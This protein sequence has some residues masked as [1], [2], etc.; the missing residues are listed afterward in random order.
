V[1]FFVLQLA[2]H[3]I[4]LVYEPYVLLVVIFPRVGNE[5]HGGIQ[6]PLTWRPAEKRGRMA[7]PIEEEY[8]EKLHGT[9]S[10]ERVSM[11]E[12]RLRLIA[13]YGCGGNGAVATANGVGTGGRR[14]GCTARGSA[15]ALAVKEYDK[16][17][18]FGEKSCDPMSICSQG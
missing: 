5:Y 10:N 1:Y 2:K 8:L 18:D 13:G 16:I 6:G 17:L 15:N 7:D 9:P 11:G 14:A 3:C 12:T 4:G